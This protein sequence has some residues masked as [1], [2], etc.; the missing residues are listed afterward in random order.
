MCKKNALPRQKNGI[1]PYFWGLIPGRADH[2]NQKTMDETPK[3]ILRGIS[4]ALDMPQKEIL[5]S[6][7]HEAAHARYIAWEYLHREDY[8]TREIADQLKTHKHN[9]IVGGLR[10]FR[11][12]GE[13]DKLFQAKLAKC[14][15]TLKATDP[16]NTR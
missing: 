16:W 11:D 15:R 3:R 9:S 7:K 14:T 12:L 1:W 4:K 2:P 6:P 8:T 5:T 10:K 13:T